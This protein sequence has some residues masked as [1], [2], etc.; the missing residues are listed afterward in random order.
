MAL[1]SEVAHL[2]TQRGVVDVFRSQE[3]AEAAR[4]LVVAWDAPGGV[5]AALDRLP[6]GVAE[7]VS[8]ALVGER[9]LPAGDH[10]RI[11]RDC[12]SR[13]ERRAAQRQLH[14]LR[15]RL[16]EAEKLGNEAEVKAELERAHQLLRRKE[17]Y[18][19]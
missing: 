4:V 6:R 15:A 19:G 16:R 1:D 13:I 2:V 12:I 3:L 14:A 5:A 11:A 17:S 18:Y 7:Q 9:T 10:L 8:A